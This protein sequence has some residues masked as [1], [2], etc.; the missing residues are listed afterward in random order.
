MRRET[1]TSGMSPS[2]LAECREN[3]KRQWENRQVD[4]EL[5]QRAWETARRLAI[6]LYR[7]FGATKVAVF[8]SL[9][10]P[11]RFRQNS[12]IDILVWG[13]SYNKCLD[14]LWETKGLDSEF[15]IDIINFKSV[16]RLFRERILSEAIPI[17]KAG[18]DAFTLVNASDR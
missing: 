15:K 7:D 9:T 5:V 13:V 10:E 2:E 11:K 14:A 12:D 6:V 3:L 17:D 18:T 8:G 16:D 1:T 4:K